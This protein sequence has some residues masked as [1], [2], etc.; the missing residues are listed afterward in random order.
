[1]NKVLIIDSSYSY[2]R[3][4]QEAGWEIVM[5][6]EEADLLQFT[7]GADVSPFLYGEQVHPQAHCDPR[8]DLVEAGYY[9]WG[10]RLG[11]KMAGICRG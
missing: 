9:A 10:V 3:M 1:M 7:G 6:I 2:Q 8:R 11:K 5:D 4:F